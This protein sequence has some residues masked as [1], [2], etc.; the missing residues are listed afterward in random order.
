M[1]IWS[2]LHPDF[3]ANEFLYVDALPLQSH[4]FL[5]AKSALVGA[6]WT[7]AF[8]ALKSLPITI[9]SPIRATSPLWTILIACVFMH[10]RP[11][12][13]QWLGIVLIISSFFAFTLVGK[14]DGIQFHRDRGVG[15][16]MVATL[17]AACSAIY[18]KYLMQNLGFRAATV[19]A[20][21]SIYLVPLMIPFAS[22]WWFRQRKVTPFRFRWSIPM[23]AA[24]LLAADYLY[25][26]ALRVDGAMISLVSPIRRVSVVVAFLAGSQLF[27]EAKLRPKAL[28]TAIMLAGVWLLALGQA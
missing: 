4:A 25:F 2:K 22:Y 15:M 27:G 11:T 28:C 6:S 9:A 1:V 14:L 8:F 26:S 20:W 5:F 18:D 21:F 19:Q 17:L 24:C 3:V 12:A 23:I 16:M 13:W 10:E 7:F